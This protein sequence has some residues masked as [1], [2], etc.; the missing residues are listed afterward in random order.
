MN[1]LEYI[2]HSGAPDFQAQIDYQIELWYEEWITAVSSNYHGD[3]LIKL[4]GHRLII[5]MHFHSIIGMHFHSICD[6]K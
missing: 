5:G 4:T 6:H 2:L 1:E 3:G